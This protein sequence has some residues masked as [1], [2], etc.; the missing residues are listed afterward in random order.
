[1]LTGS[2]SCTRKQVI[3]PGYYPGV[4][5]T[6]EQRYPG[7]SPVWWFGF[8][9]PP[10]LPP[11]IMAKWEETIQDIMKDPEFL[12]KVKDIGGVPFYRASREFKEHV[13][14]EVEEAGKLWGLK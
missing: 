7:L 13:R 5:T 9:G 3:I 10:N 8:S 12:A 6:A 2:G 1:L 14:N 11:A 4:A